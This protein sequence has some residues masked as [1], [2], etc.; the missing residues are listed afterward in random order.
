MRLLL[1]VLFAGW[2]MAFAYAFS[3]LSGIDLEAVR[4]GQMPANVMEFLRWQGVALLLA[5]AVF[6]VSLNWPRGA[7]VRGLGVL[8][9]SLAALV[10]A[11]VGIALVLI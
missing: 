7:T 2:A 3:Q 11:A 6:G 1:T 8:P 5:I 9:L 10:G 4:G